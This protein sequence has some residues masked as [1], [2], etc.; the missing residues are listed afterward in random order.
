MN[1]F[2][3]DKH[4][5]AAKSYFSELD[6]GRIPEELFAPNF[7]FWFP[8]FG[9]G[10]GLDD[11]REFSVGQI[12]AGLQVT[13]YQD[14]LKYYSVGSHVVVEGTTFGSDNAGNSWRGGETPGGRFC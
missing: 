13:H 7:E 12:S 5:S 2:S 14:R 1:A 6:A 8:K 10:H 4:V 11:L 9:V 3:S